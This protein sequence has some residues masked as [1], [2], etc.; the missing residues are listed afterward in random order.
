VTIGGLLL[1]EHGL[2]QATPA[3]LP[4]DTPLGAIRLTDAGGPVLIATDDAGNIVGLV[5]TKD[6]QDRLNAA[7]ER[8]RERWREMPLAHLVRAALP[9]EDSAS[10]S[11][12]GQ[13]VPCSVVL[14][15]GRL[16]A[17]ATCD[18]VFVSWGRLAGAVASATEDPLTGVMN[19]LGYDRRLTEEWDRARREG[20]SVGIIIVDLDDFKGINDRYGHDAGD[21]ILKSTVA[22]LK[23]SLRSY[24]V[25]ARFGGDEFVALCIGCRPDEIRI[26][27]GRILANL[28]AGPTLAANPQLRV[29]A[30]VGAAVRHDG[31]AESRPAE[32]F[33][34]ADRCLYTAKA[35]RG[36]ACWTE[37]FATRSAQ[38]LTCDEY[39]L[40]VE[41]PSR[42]ACVAQEAG[43]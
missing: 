28:A 43:N 23:A 39:P 42:D 8:E 9:I 18:D 25:L 15:R 27:L 26:P 11:S 24:D 35:T 32:L 2:R 41:A 6:I 7:N 29:S 13:R 10:A 21:E 1:L 37:F 16:I 30:S 38:L 5:S 3:S 4:Q 40:L 14:E 22:L 17:L 12:P 20:F 34:A 31:F 36:T 33:S 19:R